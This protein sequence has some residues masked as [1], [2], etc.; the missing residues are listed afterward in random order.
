[1]SKAAYYLFPVDT[2]SAIV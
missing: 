1:M 2:T